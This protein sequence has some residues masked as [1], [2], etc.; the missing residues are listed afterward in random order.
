[1]HR[2]Q[3]VR[4]IGDFDGHGGAAGAAVERELDGF[5]HANLLD[6]IAELREPADA[7]VVHRN[8]DIAQLSGGEI[9]TPQPRPF[10]RRSRNRAH[11]DHPVDAEPGRQ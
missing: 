7:L 4:D 5:S 6:A 11:D 9:D 2:S 1:M 10:G 3:R 8:D